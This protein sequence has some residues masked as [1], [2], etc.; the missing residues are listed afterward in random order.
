MPRSSGAGGASRENSGHVNTPTKH[1][2]KVLHCAA[3]SIKHDTD[4]GAAA[5]SQFICKKVNW[6]LVCHLH[7]NHD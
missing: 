6:L 2:A 3:A 7:L 1:Q 4:E 5:C